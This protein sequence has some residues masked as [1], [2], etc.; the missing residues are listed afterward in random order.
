MINREKPSW[1]GR[2]V[3][4]R[5]TFFKLRK[6]KGTDCEDLPS[7]ECSADGKVV[8]DPTLLGYFFISQTYMF[9]LLWVIATRNIYLINT[10]PEEVSQCRGV[11]K[12][13]MA[14][15]TP[16]LFTDRISHHVF[17]PRKF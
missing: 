12:L 6:G 11:K 13:A 7:P 9:G 17:G 3:S 10:A 16:A 15:H 5:S 2:K 8:V 14:I 4:Y 1:W